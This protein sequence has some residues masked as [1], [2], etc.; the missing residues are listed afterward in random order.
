[1][2]NVKSQKLNSKHIALL[3]QERYPELVGL[4]DDWTGLYKSINIRLC[5]FNLISR[6]TPEDIIIEV[7]SRWHKTFE[8]RKQV[9]SVAGWMRVTALNCIRELKRQEQ[10][11]DLYD[12]S[13]LATK[14]SNNENSI[15]LEDVEDNRY[16]CVRTAMSQLSE[17]KRELLELRFIQELSWDEVA[18]YYAGQGKKFKVTALRKRGQRAL[19]DLRKVFF[20]MVQQ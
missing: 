10:K 5:Q 16:Q 3:L 17:D 15:V 12:P 13:V 18:A 7:I 20:E 2:T 11:A 6:Y 8:K 14:I 9:P 1:V 4:V 19:E